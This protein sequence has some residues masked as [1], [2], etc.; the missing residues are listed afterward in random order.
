MITFSAAFP[1]NKSECDVKRGPLSFHLEGICTLLLFVLNFVSEET[2]ILEAHLH[3]NTH[4]HIVVSKLA[5]N[6]AT[7]YIIYFTMMDQQNVAISNPVYFCF[8]SLAKSIAQQ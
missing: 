6:Q 8:T 4:M 1:N 2:D 7:A 3:I 5:R